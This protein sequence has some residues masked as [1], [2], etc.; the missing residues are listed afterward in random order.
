MPSP[1]SDGQV[2]QS[3]LQFEQFSPADARQVPS[4]Q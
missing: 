1:Q 2:P 4:P 3:F